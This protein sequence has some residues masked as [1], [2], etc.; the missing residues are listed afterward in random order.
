[1]NLTEF[2]ALLAFAACI[3]CQNLAKQSGSHLEEVFLASSGV[4]LPFMDPFTS[5]A[6]SES[7]QATLRSRTCHHHPRPWKVNGVDRSPSSRVLTADLRE[8]QGVHA[9]A[10][11]HK[12][13]GASGRLE[14]SP[15]SWPKH[16]SIAHT[17]R[18]MTS[19]SPE[20]LPGCSVL[21]LWVVGK[22]ETAGR[23]SANLCTCESFPFC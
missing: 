12:A 8:L 6:S 15:N 7:A 20:T 2:K 4:F 17:K 22:N 11:H 23:S 1:M 10:V 3:S 21:R 18:H 13:L 19:S 14:R 16:L 5:T 9:D